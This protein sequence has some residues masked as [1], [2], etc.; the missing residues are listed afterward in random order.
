ME[1]GV[2]DDPAGALAEMSCSDTEVG[3]PVGVAGRDER[4]LG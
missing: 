4:S 1:W 3:Q 2:Q